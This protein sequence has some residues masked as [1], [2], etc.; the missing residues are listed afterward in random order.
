MLKNIKSPMKHL[1]ILF[2]VSLLFSCQNQQPRQEATEALPDEILPATRGQLLGEWRNVYTKVTMNTYQNSD[3]TKV[4]EVEE[5]DWEKVMQAK[6]IR[7]FF[8][9][10]GTYNSE[11]R[12]LN[13]SIIYNPAGRWTM[14]GDSLYM[15]DTFPK[16]GVSYKYRILLTGD[17]LEFRGYEDFDQDGMKDDI[18]HGTQRKQ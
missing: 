17:L 12:N 15:T 11:H 18:Y 13:D 2:C 10:D 7:T 8:R 1:A 5:A 4:L 3:S 16:R 14:T 6:P 9:Q